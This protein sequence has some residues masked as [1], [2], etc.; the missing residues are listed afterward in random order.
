MRSFLAPIGSVR[1]SGGGK[2]PTDVARRA[3]SRVGLLPCGGSWRFRANDGA[4]ARQGCDGIGS[5]TDREV[6]L[7]SQAMPIL[8][9]QYEVVAVQR[10]R[11]ATSQRPSK[12]AS[13]GASG[14]RLYVNEAP[15]AYGF[16]ALIPAG[17]EL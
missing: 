13:V 2:F 17:L 8:D 14:G 10:K 6:L 1:F 11:Q 5:R 7:P 3:L 16:A 12:Y 9:R 4:A 15:V